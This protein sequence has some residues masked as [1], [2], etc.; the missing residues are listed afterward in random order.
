MAS[1]VAFQEA[2]PPAV[3]Q[4]GANRLWLEQV[5]RSQRGGLS[6]LPFQ[7]GLDERSYAELIRTY[8][9][10]LATQTS[11]GLGSLAHECSE[12]REDL[13]EMRR[14]EWE[15]LR[16]LLLGSRRGDAPEEVWI[17]SIVA[18]A[19]LGGDHLWRDLGLESRQQLHDLLT[20]NFPSLAARNVRN[21]RWK[22]FFYKQLCEQEGGY[23]CRSPSC[24]QCPTYHDCFGEEV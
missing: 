4:D 15:E 20:H 10:A 6:C 14:D 7:L 16:D 21:M 1:A 5:V 8:F 19:C 23:V 24:E 22:K 11:A 17:A 9:P 12:L 13:L 3:R 18:A 2:I